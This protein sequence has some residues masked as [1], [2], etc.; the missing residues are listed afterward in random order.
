MHEQR[1]TLLIRFLCGCVFILFLG[2]FF[3]SVFASR[4]EQTVSI[5]LFRIGQTEVLIN[6]EKWVMDAAPELKNHRT[7]IP[8]RFLA[9][10]MGALVTWKENPDIPGEG[11]VIIQFSHSSGYYKKIILHTNHTTVFVETK[12]SDQAQP[13]VQ[14]S[15]LDVA[16]YIKIPNNRTL[17]PLRFVSES[18]GAQVTWEEQTQQV[19]VTWNGFFPPST[20][21]STLFM[22]QPKPK[23]EWS[24]QLRSASVQRGKFIQPTIDGGYILCGSEDLSDSELGL[25][26]AKLN[27]EGTPEWEKRLVKESGLISGVFVN[28]TADNGYLVVGNY[29][30]PAI[31]VD[32]DIVLYRLN[33]DGVLLWEKNIGAQGDDK[34]LSVKQT[35]D[36]GYVMTGYSDSYSNQGTDILFFKTDESG[37]VIW[38]KIFGKNS[39]EIGTGC[40]ETS[41]GDILVCGSVLS[42]QGQQQILLMKTNPSGEILWQ[43]TYG[44]KG[45]YLINAMMEANDNGVLLMGETDS[46]SEQEGIYLLKTDSFGSVLWEKYY[47]KNGSTIGHSFAQTNSG[48]LMIAGTTNVS[49]DDLLSESGKADGYLL[50]TD[51]YGN[52]IWDLVLEGEEHDSLVYITR[53]P[54]LGFILC[55]KSSSNESNQIAIWLVKLYPIIEDEALLEVNPDSIAFGVIEKNSSKITALL[56]IAN[57]GSQNLKGYIEYSQTWLVVSDQSFIIPGFSSLK[58]LVSLLP[59]QLEEGNAESYLQITSNGGKKRVRITCTIVDNSPKLWVYPTEFDFGTIPNRDRKKVSFSIANYGRKNLSGTIQSTV[60]WL[61]VH[62]TEFMNND[63]E[64]EVQ[65]RP[66]ILKNGEYK[67]LIEIRSNG[68]HQSVTVR[69]KCQFPIITIYFCVNHPEVK[70]NQTN[71]MFDP[72][73]TEIVPFIMEGR[74]LVPFRFIGEAFGAT[75]EWEGTTKQILVSLDSKEITMILTVNQ[76]EAIIN[77]EKVKMDVPPLI[78][79]NRVF[80]PI[81]FIAEA[82]GAQVNASKSSDGETCVTIVYEQ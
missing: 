27:N 72:D 35:R 32:N 18:V 45:N 61:T 16:P 44:K 51:A 6:Q 36:R 31:S 43:K 50:F 58:V 56:T 22:S 76:K 69:I 5:F 8:L 71:T 63:T 34:V 59:N 57:N 48:G 10:K 66:S 46:F 79:K 82:F 38:Q 11:V 65:L 9:E 54:D 37:N 13:S 19:T 26:V 70:I 23:M 81:R 41:E 68:G 1:T 29:A 78:F 30:N 4:Q 25:Y 21:K 14:T 7:F 20:T 60:P 73:H 80:V 24:R 55:G 28:Q 62:P 15:V 12:L 77:Q 67:G 52:K 49:I 17:V 47:E 40:L 3:N 64:V 75:L 42:I 53:S 39:D 2:G 33:Q 74:T